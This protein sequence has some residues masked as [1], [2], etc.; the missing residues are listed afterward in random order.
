MNKEN[1][2]MVAYTAFIIWIILLASSGGLS[3]VFFLIKAVPFADK[4]AHFFLMGTLALVVNI[5]FK[6]KVILFGRFPIFLASI[7]VLFFVVL[8]EFSQI[9]NIYRT[10]DWY[11][12]LADLLGI[13]LIPWLG[14]KYFVKQTQTGDEEPNKQ[15]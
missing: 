5:S 3:A 2:I 6:Y 14:K 13:I 12:L 7:V 1:L 9:G 15:Y 8:E 4:V 10:F 11:D